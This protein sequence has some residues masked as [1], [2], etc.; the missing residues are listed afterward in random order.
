MSNYQVTKKL[1]PKSCVVDGIDPKDYP[2]F[3]DA[4]IVY[5]EWSDGVELTDEEL[6]T[7]NDNQVGAEIAQTLAY[8]EYF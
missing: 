3:V 5:A 4:F 7:L 8:E 6:D 1:N 2:D